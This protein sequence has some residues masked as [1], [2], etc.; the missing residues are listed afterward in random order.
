MRPIER[1]KEAQ[2]VLD[3]EASAIF[4][5]SKKIGLNFSQCIDLIVN[6][7]GTV[8]ISGIGKS[9]SIGKKIT[10][11][12]AS[13]GTPSTFLHPSDAFHGD[14]GIIRKNDIIILISNSGETYE[15][16]KLLDFAKKNHI[17][18]IAI[19][20][21]L[22]S[23]ISKEASVSIDASVEN[24]ACPLNLAP[25]CSTAV[26]MALGDALASICAIEKGFQ[27]IDFARFHPS[28]KLHKLNLE[29]VDN[30]MNTEFLPICDKDT[31]IKELI[32]KISKGQQG[33]VF[34]C[35]KKKL[36]WV[37]TD[38]DLRRC[39]ESGIKLTSKV[40]NLRFSSPLTIKSGSKVAEALDIMKLNKISIL[41]IIDDLG[42]LMG[43]L[44]LSQCI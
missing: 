39:I 22:E 2:K 3:S 14:L 27:E 19:T 10:S 11:T 29:I 15:I 21:N 24:E 12:L 26:T 32:I 35:E 20:G 9:G 43:S 13:L 28:G 23:T 40:K 8:I 34:I 16:V 7:K 42:F 36:L 41:P 33:A 17:E 37:F 31:T 25:T 6:C 38:G 18:S 1:I 30:I 44:K 5:T 4:S